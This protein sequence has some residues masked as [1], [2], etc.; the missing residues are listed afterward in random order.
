MKKDMYKFMP[1][2]FTIIG[3]IT[4][5]IN[6]LIY[7]LVPNHLA[8][9]SVS[10]L[11]ISGLCCLWGIAFKKSL[12]RI[13]TDKSTGIYDREYFY[14]II[15]NRLRK[16]KNKSN[17]MS[18][19]MIDVDNFKKV[20][21]NFGHIAGDELIREV[22]DIIKNSIRE[23]DYA[24]RWG[25]DEFVVVF[26]DIGVEHAGKIAERIREAIEEKYCNGE[27]CFLTASIGV[28]PI[29]PEEDIENIVDMVDKAMYKAKKTKNTV[30][31][32]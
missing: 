13:Y 23:S 21:D 24:V 2:I 15:D 6:W 31:G 29:I 30:S 18:I 9:L 16:N 17:P 25:G 20:N 4:A 32:L 11:I 26:P 3:F 5:L 14:H 8:A 12:L 10:C 27:L 1:L 19:A 22:A 28:I 7:S